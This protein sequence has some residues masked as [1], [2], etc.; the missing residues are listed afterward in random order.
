MYQAQLQVS[1][2]DI[3]TVQ[4]QTQPSGASFTP[5]IKFGQLGAAYDS[6]QYVFALSNASTALVAGNIQTALAST[7]NH[8]GRTLT[9]SQAALG[10]IGSTTVQVTVGATLVSLNQYLQ[11][12]LTVIA[13]TGIG[14]QYRIKGNS[15]AISS[16]TTT[17]SLVDPI[18]VAFDSTTVVTLYPNPW[19]GV[20]VSSTTVASNNIVG[21]PNIAVAV[22]NYCWL[23]VDGYCA[24]LADSSPPTKNTNAVISSTTAGSVTIQVAAN[25]TQVIG[26]APETM[27]SAQTQ[28]LFLSIQ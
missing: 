6:K 18:L 7:A 15:A 27:V 25:V 3:R 23:Q 5:S 8:A 12:Y 24:T 14:G 2:Q 21:V 19:N 22:S 13:G 28:N 1:E 4:P 11:G 10:T 9:A 17:L 16:G 20:A 26:Y